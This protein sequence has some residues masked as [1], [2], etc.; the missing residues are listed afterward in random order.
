MG[1]PLIGTSGMV[2]LLTGSWLWDGGRTARSPV[3][4]QAV[5]P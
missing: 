4:Y 3:L 2:S 5:V 1:A